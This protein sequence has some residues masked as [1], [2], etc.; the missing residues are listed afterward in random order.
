MALGQD[1][2]ESLRGPRDTTAVNNLFTMNINDT[3]VAKNDDIKEDD[4]LWMVLMD[5]SQLIMT[6]LGLIANIV[7]CI[8]LIK[9]KQVS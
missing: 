6:V 4:P 1:E 9:N 2:T 7:T 3:F 8:T 5:R